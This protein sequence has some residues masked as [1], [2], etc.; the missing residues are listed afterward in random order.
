MAR[1]RRSKLVPKQ[2]EAPKAEGQ[3]QAPKQEAPPVLPPPPPP[4]PSEWAKRGE[5]RRKELRERFERQREEFSLRP[6]REPPLEPDDILDTTVVEGKTVA[7]WSALAESIREK[8]WRE[9][10][11][12]IAVA[13]LSPLPGWSSWALGAWE[14]RGSPTLRGFVEEEIRKL[15]EKREKAQRKLDKATAENDVAEKAKQQKVVTNAEQEV[16]ERR[17]GLEELV[18]ELSEKSASPS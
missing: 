9:R 5:V 13:D 11:N 7:E 18:K 12:G 16:I 6:V 14:R 4:E 8:A 10:K 2:I 15:E 3:S 1:R 17:K